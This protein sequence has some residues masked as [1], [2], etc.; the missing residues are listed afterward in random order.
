M[1]VAT[2]PTM[3]ALRLGGVTVRLRVGVR[4]FVVTG[5]KG[6]AVCTAELWKEEVE[7][8]HLLDTTAWAIGQD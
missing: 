4:C 5:H 8:R 6:G 7:E 1:E 2:H 3:L